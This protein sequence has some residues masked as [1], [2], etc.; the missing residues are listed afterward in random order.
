MTLPATVGISEVGA[1]SGAS[2]AQ[3][4][5]PTTVESIA[6]PVPQA[7]TASGFSVTVFGA[8]NTST[9]TI[10]LASA[11][12]SGV[13]SGQVQSSALS[14]QVVADKGNPVTCSTSETLALTDQDFVALLIYFNASDPDYDNTRVTSSFVCQ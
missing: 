12:A 2:V 5:S 9:A 3:A 10:A 14:C 11:S 1:A 8:K 4:P 6:L 13:S 7:C